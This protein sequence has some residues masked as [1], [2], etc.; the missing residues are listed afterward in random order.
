MN[1]PE[2]G[3]YAKIVL[4]LRPVDTSYRTIVFTVPWE[5]LLHEDQ[6]V[7]ISNRLLSVNDPLDE[8][9]HPKYHLQSNY[10]FTLQVQTRHF[11]TDLNGRIPTK[12]AK[13]D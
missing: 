13:L 4:R 2:L 11:G 5:G 7:G 1:R 3:L 8:G 6:N 10:T 9:R 12:A